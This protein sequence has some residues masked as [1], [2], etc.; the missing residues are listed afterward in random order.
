MEQARAYLSQAVDLL[1]PRPPCLIAVGGLSG[2]GKS[3]VAYGLAPALGQVPGA[4]VLRSDVLRKN[5]FGVTSTQRLP[6]SAYGE[7]VTARVY[8]RMREEAVAVLAAGRCVI[9]D[10]LH[11]RPAEREAVADVARA[12]GVPFVGLWLE[13]PAAVLTA[14][15][16]ARR[17]DASDATVDVL[18][19]QLAYDLGPMSWTRVD[20]GGA[21]EAVIAAA[22]RAAA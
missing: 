21:L 15:I 7:D 1:Q 8:R 9:A 16:A 12:A 22:R 2:S 5:L 4:R 18:K 17:D 19:R 11:A 14:R 13:A 6:P 3:S 10:A 20:A